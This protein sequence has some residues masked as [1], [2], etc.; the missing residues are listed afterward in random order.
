M[1]FVHIVGPFVALLIGALLV[2]WCVR[3][4]NAKLQQAEA[5]MGAMAGAAG[6]V[7]GPVYP[8]QAGGAPPP[9]YHQGPPPMA[10]YPQQAPSGYP[11][12]AVGYP[13]VGAA[14]GPPAA[15]AA[16]PS[17]PPVTVPQPGGGAT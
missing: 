1:N 11:A 9:A 3:S 2:M 16:Y 5:Q 4:R 8:Q 14:A 10:G 13:A 7:P 15:S 6:P 12:A 17:M